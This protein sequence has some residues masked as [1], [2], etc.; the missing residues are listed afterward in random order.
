M[1]KKILLVTLFDNNNI[2]NRLQN[3]ALYKVLQEKNVE[4]DVLDN[5][6]TIKATIK[7]E[8]KNSIKF[9]LGLLGFKKYKIKHQKYVFFRR[10]QKANIAFNNKNIPTVIKMKNKKIFDKDWSEYDLAIVGSDQVWHNWNSCEN[11]LSYYYLN[12][13]SDNKRVA[14]AA[15]FG[16]EEFPEKDYLQHKQGIEQ[17]KFISC[18]EKTGCGLVKQI[19][20]KDVPKVL[21]PT[22]L[23]TARE[24]MKIGE[25]ASEITKS[26]KNFAFVFFLGKQSEEYK[27]YIN[28]II[29]ELGVNKIIDFNDFKNTS[30]TG[31]SPEGFVSLINNADYIFTDSFHCTVF[32]LLFNKEFTV[33]RRHQP[34]M[35]KMFSRIEEL[36]ASK[37]KLGNIYGGSTMKATNDF[38]KLYSQSMEYIDSVL[39]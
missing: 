14:Y 22:L 17:M 28:K 2:G 5:G 4:V 26:Q 18:R 34:G 37:N 8:F 32:S 7:D 25:Q 13:I 20:K 39:K 15:S 1:K 29:V 12:F 21:D 11:E 24:W 30:I 31:C 33:F 38:E 35:E 27:K 3:F 9:F 36:L 10:R 16:F 6:Y 23:L 19:I